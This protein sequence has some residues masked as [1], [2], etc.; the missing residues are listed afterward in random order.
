MNY[1]G[2]D[3]R[4]IV[5]AEDDQTLA[6]FLRR[7]LDDEGYQA[8]IVETGHEALRLVAALHPDVVV[9]D[10]GLPDA[11]GLDICRQIKNDARSADI[12]VLFLT[13][14]NE[15]DERIEGLDAGAQDYLTKPFAMPEF[16]ARLRAILRSQDDLRQQREQITQRQEELMAVIHHEMRGPLTVISMASQILAENHQISPERHDQL[17]QSIR[18]SAGSLNH[19]VDDLVYLMS[20]TRTLRTCQLRPLVQGVVEECRPRVHE[21]GLH[22]AARLPHDLPPLVVD[23]THL[24]RALRHLIDNAIKFTPR[25]GI[26]TITVAAIQGGQ[27]VASEPGTEEEIITATPEALLPADDAEPWALIAVRDTGIGIAP[28]H[29]HHVFEP[30]YQIDSSAARTAQG[31]GLG[32]AVVAAFVRSHHGHLAVRSGN[33][34]GTEIHLALPLRQPADTVQQSHIAPPDG[35][36][37]A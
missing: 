6:H 27:V 20:P 28:E 23:E 35:P 12:P 4:I 8:H 5:V 22:L 24:R 13:G 2:R 21:H 25:G 11:S 31:L 10:V 16:Q 37:G 36:E 1:S 26:I 7:N 32:L 14:K 17:I 30:F 9:L 33:G 18:N 29:H 15:L 19:I 3:G 34:M